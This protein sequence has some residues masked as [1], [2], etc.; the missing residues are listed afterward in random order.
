MRN[1]CILYVK[2]LVFQPYIRS[3]CLV[4]YI[5]HTTTIYGNELYTQLYYTL[6]ALVISIPFNIENYHE[7]KTTNLTENV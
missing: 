7:K 3:L 5:F 2:V 6:R 1:I 4:I